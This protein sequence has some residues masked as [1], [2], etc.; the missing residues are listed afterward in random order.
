[1]TPRTDAPQPANCPRLP[2]DENCLEPDG[3][4]TACFERGDRDE[5]RRRW[6]AVLQHGTQDQ[7]DAMR[8]EVLNRIHTR[9]MDDDPSYLEAGWNP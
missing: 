8:D 7:I 3:P 1:M 4:C 2:D 6:N 9:I 5:E